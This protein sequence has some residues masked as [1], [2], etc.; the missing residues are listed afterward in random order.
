M[1]MQMIPCYLSE[2]KPLYFIAKPA[3]PEEEHNFM[4]NGSIP[5]IE[6]GTILVSKT[7][8][9]TS[10]FFHVKAKKKNQYGIILQ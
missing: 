8:W 3:L 1:M 4:N 6:I 10:T 5:E 2:P 9:T 7:M